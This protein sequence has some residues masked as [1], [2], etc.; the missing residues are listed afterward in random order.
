MYG[1]PTLVCRWIVC[2]NP[3][4]FFF[5]F[6]FLA[7][8]VRR[9]VPHIFDSCPF[10]FHPSWL[11][12]FFFTGCSRVGYNNNIIWTL[13]A[14]YC[15]FYSTY[16]L[17]YLFF[18]S[19]C[20]VCRPLTAASPDLRHSLSSSFLSIGLRMPPYT[21]THTVRWRKERE[22]EECSNSSCS[23]SSAPLGFTHTHSAET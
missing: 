8:S 14:F 11:F 12:L 3:S 22:E 5:L 23:T 9:I 21:H 16:L 6:R 20:I 15:P 17:T 1:A 19:G 7:P 13:I 4:F 18:F 10:S 2:E